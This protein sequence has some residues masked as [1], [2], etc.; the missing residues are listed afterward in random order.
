LAF[1]AAAEI[2]A[3]EGDVGTKVVDESAAFED[4]GIEPVKKN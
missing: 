2:E 3:A 4:V 1:T